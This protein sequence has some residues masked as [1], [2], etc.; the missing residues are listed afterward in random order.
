MIDWEGKL[1]VK[2]Q[3]ELLD[4][5]RGGVYYTLRPVSEQDLQLMRR[6]DHSFG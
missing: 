5:N 4:L 3:C 6:I 2:R 1:S